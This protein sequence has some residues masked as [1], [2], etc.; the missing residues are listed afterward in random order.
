MTLTRDELLARLRLMRGGLGAILSC[1]ELDA[2]MGELDDR[3]CATCRWAEP[4][5]PELLPDQADRAAYPFICGA[6]ALP[7]RGIGEGQLS[8][9][10]VV[11]PDFG[12]VQYEARP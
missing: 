5:D 6:D 10:V 7:M 12:C 11:A 3:R 8:G 1:D 2:L 9:P 4:T